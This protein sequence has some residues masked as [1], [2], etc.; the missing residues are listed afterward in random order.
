VPETPCVVVDLQYVHG[1]S[2]DRF[3]VDD[4]QSEPSPSVSS[5]GGAVVSE[6]PTLVE[7]ILDDPNVDFTDDGSAMNGMTE[8]GPGDVSAGITFGWIGADLALRFGLTPGHEDLRPFRYLSFRAC[9]STRAA[10]NV[11]ALGDQ[12]FEVALYDHAGVSSAIGIGAYGGGIE[13]PYQRAGCGLGVGWANEFETIRIRLED[14]T[15][16]ASGIDLSD[17]D[18]IEIRCGPAHGSKTGKIGFDD[19]ELERE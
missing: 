13:A 10:E 9:Q 4:F 2:P 14:F 8:C 5:S 15:R 16:N 1:P 18:W 17:V 12:L 19:L 11:V 3:V 6:F 7:G